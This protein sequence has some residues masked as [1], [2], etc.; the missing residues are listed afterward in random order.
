MELVSLLVIWFENVNKL[1]WKSLQ[2]R[3]EKEEEEV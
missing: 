2:T 3:R 1:N